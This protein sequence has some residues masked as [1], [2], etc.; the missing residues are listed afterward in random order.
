MQIL[1]M[2]PFFR[3]ASHVMNVL[4]EREQWSR[5]ELEALQLERIN[6]VW[7]HAVN[8]VPYYRRLFRE[9]DLPRRFESLNQYRATVPVLDKTTV[10]NDTLLSERPRRGRW[11]RTSGSTGI[12]LATFW[13]KDADLEMACAQ[14]RSRA[15]WGVEI[16]DRSAMFSGYGGDF[17][18]GWRGRVAKLRRPLK[19]HLRRRMRLSV[20]RLG[21]EDLRRHIRC[22]RDFGPVLLYGYSSAIYL[23]ALQA[24]ETGLSIDSLKLVVMT[25]EVVTQDMRDTVQR[26]F[27]TNVVQE[28]GAAECPVIAYEDNQH[29]LR[30]RDD[31]VIVETLPTESN[32][33]RIIISILNNP[34]F[35]LL[36]YDIGDLTD[37]PVVPAD[38]G[39]GILGPVIGKRNDLL[40]SRSGRP[41]CLSHSWLPYMIG[42]QNQVKRFRIHQFSDGA[43]LALLE[44]DSS[45]KIDTNRVREKLITLL[46]GQPVEVKLTESIPPISSGKHR[47]IV[48][49]LAHS[50]L[51]Q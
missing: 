44:V 31:L 49:E 10:R 50:S 41:V 43:V 48:S 11:E 47:W 8:H 32:H 3:K 13:E 20:H 45:G 4:E 1:K 16:F 42:Q 9:R 21:K 29:N 36:R 19:D 17:A 46:E 40:I 22:M 37:K 15:L 18:P 34:S 7:D 6:Q 26:A 27:H 14:Y 35:P 12:P 5:S 2:H 51:A 28:Y 33:Y 39:F 30:V 23:L 38:D 24:L 25:S